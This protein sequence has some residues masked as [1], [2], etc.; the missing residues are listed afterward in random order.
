MKVCGNCQEKIYFSTLFKNIRGN[1]YKYTCARCGAVHRASRGSRLLFSFIF[2]VPFSIFA[3]EKMLI[4][5]IIWILLSF[6]VIEPF[7]IQFEKVEVV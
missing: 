3:I 6:F 5:N 1:R 2:V 4:P 7:V